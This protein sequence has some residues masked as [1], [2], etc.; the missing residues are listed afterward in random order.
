MH[1]RLWSDYLICWWL[2]LRS[3]WRTIRTI[4][5]RWYCTN[6]NLTSTLSPPPPLLPQCLSHKWSSSQPSAVP[7]HHTCH[8]LGFYNRGCVPLTHWTFMVRRS[9]ACQRT[10]WM[11]EPSLHLDFKLCWMWCDHKWSG[12]TRCLFTCDH[13]VFRCNAYIL[14]LPAQSISSG[15]YLYYPIMIL[16]YLIILIKATS[17]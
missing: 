4:G 11:V 10:I 2:A 7:R 16:I 14:H 1:F 13:F 17:K 5:S 3:A 8:L 15:Y 9:W 6:P 12:E